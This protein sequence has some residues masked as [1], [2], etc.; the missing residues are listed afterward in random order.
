MSEVLGLK[1]G[2]FIHTME[3][4]HIYSNAFDVAEELIAREPVKFPTLKLVN[5]HKDIFDYR[6]EDFAL[7][8]YHPHAAIKSIPIG[9]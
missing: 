6:R 7:E 9:V 3:N 5:K 1:P 8:D 2:E 4:A